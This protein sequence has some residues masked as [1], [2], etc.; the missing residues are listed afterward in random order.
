MTSWNGFTTIKIY[1]LEHLQRQKVYTLEHE[2][3]RDCASRNCFAITLPINQLYRA[4]IARFA[5]Y[6]API[7]DGSASK[8]CCLGV[9]IPMFIGVNMWFVYENIFPI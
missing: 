1:T 4:A 5:G 7:K 2:C 3:L 6:Q 9:R 8:A